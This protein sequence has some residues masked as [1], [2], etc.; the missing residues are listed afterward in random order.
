M[1]KN[2]EVSRWVVRTEVLEF[3][4]RN[5]RI[6]IKVPG[7][8]IISHS[9]YQG[10][11]RVVGNLRSPFWGSDSVKLEGVQTLF[12]LLVLSSS[13]GL[14]RSV[15]RLQTLYGC[16]SLGEG[17]PHN[18]C[19]PIAQSKCQ[20]RADCSYCGFLENHYCEDQRI[21]YIKDHYEQLSKKEMKCFKQTCKNKV[22]Q[23]FPSN[24]HFILTIP[25]WY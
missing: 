25:I 15:G 22:F 13:Q 6:N 23:S 18:S 9:S 17:Y 11:G 5:V 16:G 8:Q 14:Q 19:P 4:I 12:L 21:I 3:I 7:H 24:F 10:E 2:R 1:S 20:C